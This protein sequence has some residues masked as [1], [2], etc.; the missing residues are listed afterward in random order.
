MATIG[1]LVADGSSSP[2]Q[3]ALLTLQDSSQPR[4]S[5]GEPDALSAKVEFFKRVETRFKRCKSFE[6]TAQA[7]YKEDTRFATGDS[8]NNWQ[9]DSNMIN[10]R[11]LEKKPCLTINK[12]RQHNLQIVNDA[13]QNKPG[14]KMRPSGGKASFKAAEA[15]TGIARYIEYQSKAQQIYDDAMKTLVD[16]G[17]GYWRVVTDYSF[18]DFSEQDIRIKHIAN[19]LN[20]YVDPDDTTPDKSELN[21]AFIFEMNDEDTTKQKFPQWNKEDGVQTLEISPESPFMD[22]TGVVVCE[23]YERTWT[24]ERLFRNEKGVVFKES[25]LNDEQIDLFE[26]LG[27]PQRNIRTP[28]VTWYLIAGRSILDSRVIPCKYVPVVQICAEEV[29]IGTDFDRKSHTRYLKD[30]ARMYNY[31]SSSAVEYGALQTKTPWV[32]AAEA[33]EGHED[34][35][36]VANTKNPAFLP[37]NGY[38]EAGK[39]IPPPMRVAPPMSAPVALDGMKIAQME[40]MMASGQYDNTMGQQGNERTGK[41]IN[42]RQR[43]GDN[44]TYHY[45]DA[46]ARGVQLTGR[47]ILSMLPFIYDTK[48]ILMMLAMDDSSQPLQIDPAQTEAYKE[49]LDVQGKVIERILNPKVGFYEVQADTGPGYATQRQEAFDSMALILT[50]NPAMAALIG[51][52]MLRAGDFPMADEAAERLKRMVPK[53]ALG[54]GPSASE[55]A[56][57]MQIQ[58]MQGTIQALMDQLVIGESKLVRQ[59]EKSGIEKYNAFT[60]RIKVILDS[61]KTAAEL[62]MEFVSM[63]NDFMMESAKTTAAMDQTNMA[64][65]TP[66]KPLPAPVAEERPLGLDGGMVGQ[67]FM[68]SSKPIIPNAMGG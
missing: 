37:Y 29:R 61:E 64:D 31:W 2:M 3:S 6:S 18:G 53:E 24:D 51:D 60:Q 9:W 40:L 13:R 42:A 5:V 58:T 63:M 28:I 30:A 14:I 62:K 25:E 33:F 57:Q 39:I 17:V 4:P 46:L 20:V 21:F 35:W 52:I 59:G 56:L 43:Q 67:R 54:E 22:G 50:Q 66:P 16:G 8:D 45:I 68:S 7:R 12:T 26:S 32:G 47:I 15:I 11:T 38:D 41:A 44:A 1:E 34:M 23:Y 19:P 10:E 36:A 65:G 55:K 27:L 48:R 49:N